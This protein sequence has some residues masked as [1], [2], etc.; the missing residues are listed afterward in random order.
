MVITGRGEDAC[1]WVGTHDG[2]NRID[3]ATRR[4]DRYQHRPGD[5]YSLGNNYLT[6]L[7]EDPQG[8][9]W[10]GTNQGFFLLNRRQKSF[11]SIVPQWTTDNRQTAITSVLALETGEM[12]A[13]THGMGLLRISDTYGAQA[14]TIPF[15]L[16]PQ[17]AGGLSNDITA[18]C[19]DVRGQIW[20]ATNGG[21]LYRF[22]PAGEDAPHRQVRP[23]LHI[24]ASP[25]VDTDLS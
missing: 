14:Q 13:G 20:V 25:A 16:D 21:G 22:D 18:L 11:R 23:Q 2:L 12:W 3:I 17:D 7:Y 9:L 1:V 8:M 10:I 24:W 4:I 15:A 6:C 19:R 5:P